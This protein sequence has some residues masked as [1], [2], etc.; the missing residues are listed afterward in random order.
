LFDRHN[1]EVDRNP[2]I[3]T[4]YHHKIHRLAIIEVSFLMRHVRGEVDDI[5]RPNLGGKFEPLPKRISL[6]P[7]TT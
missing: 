7:L 6:R 5:T 3:V 4:E 2:F 1:V